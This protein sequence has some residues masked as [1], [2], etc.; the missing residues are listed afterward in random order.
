MTPLRNKDSRNLTMLTD[1][2]Q[3][4]MMQAYG[5]NS[6]TVAHFDLFFRNNGQTNYAVAAGL[7]SVID[8]INDLEFTETDL[9]YLRSTNLF[10]NDFLESLKSFR[11]TGDIRAVTEGT[12]IFPQE[13]ILTVRAP[14]HEAQLIESAM[15]TLLNHQTLIATKASKISLTAAPASVFEYGLRRAQG[16]DAG[17]YGARSAVIGGCIGTSNVLAAKMFGLDAVGTHSHSF[18]LSFDS[19][20]AA[21]REYAR[22]Y[23][24]S[25]LLLV[26][27]YDTLKSGLPNAIKVFDELRAG[28]HKPVGIRLDSGDLAYLS[29]VARKMLD[30]AGYKDALI[31]ASGDI[32][33]NVI[34]HLKTQGAKIDCYGVGTKLIT[35]ADQPALGGVYKLSAIEQGGKIYPKMKFSNSEEKMTNP[36][37]KEL[38]RL[39]SPDGFAI[40]DLIALKG[41][42][43]S[44]P[45]TI[46]HPI[47][48]WKSMTLE[49][50]TMK[51]LLVPIF[52]NGRQVYTVPSINDIAANAR[53]EMDKLW[54]E[55]KRIINPHIYKVD[56]SDGLY[57][58]KQ[59]LISNQGGKPFPDKGA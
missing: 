33:E 20:L 27:S 47:E 54:D 9:Q 59:S 43:F 28:G 16:A 24:N 25:C 22:M 5:T 8:Y 4:T 12:V 14:I 21:F 32:D 10:S 31:F 48:R 57:N 1:L 45:L 34:L 3:L 11:F 15:L 39:Y 6:G 55:Y 40:A 30:D 41:E 50:F 53:A 19:E 18:V 17:I 49:D 56:Y 44:K 35:S 37:V 2:Y 42:T 38:Y 58:L 13:P 23:P 29:K 51:S 36:G 52:E 26:D 7:N 46:T